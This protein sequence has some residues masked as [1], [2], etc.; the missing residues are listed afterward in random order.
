MCI[1]MIFDTVADVFLLSHPTG[2]CLSSAEGGVWEDGA[3]A[4]GDGE[5]RGQCGVRS[6]QLWSLWTWAQ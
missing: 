6:L 2:V 4:E 5:S 1:N 3:P